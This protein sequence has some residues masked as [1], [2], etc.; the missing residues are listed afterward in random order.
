M[1]TYKEVWVTY[2]AGKLFS[3]NQKKSFD[4]ANTGRDVEKR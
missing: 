3:V 1:L 4:R 2:V